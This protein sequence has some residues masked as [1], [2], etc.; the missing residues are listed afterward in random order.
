MPLTYELDTHTE[1][2]HERGFL[3]Q[4]NHL[5]AV[6]LPPTY[7][8]VQEVAHQ[9]PILLTERHLRTRVSSMKELSIEPSLDGKQLRKLKQIYAYLASAWVQAKGE[10]NISYIPRQIAVPL[11]QL[12][13]IL[14]VQPIVT[15]EDY[16]L[17]NWKKKDTEGPFIFDNMELIQHFEDQEGD[18]DGFILIHTDIEGRG[19]SRVIE[20]LEHAKLAVEFDQPHMV[21]DGLE[22]SADGLARMNRTMARMPETCR[23]ERYAEFV[24]PYIFGFNE[25]RYEG[26]SEKPLSFHG[27][28][29]AQSSIVPCIDEALGIQH[30]ETGLTKLLENMRLYMPPR[31][32]AV[33]A[34]MAEGQA[35]RAYAQHGPVY[36]RTAYNDCIHEL[37]NF[38]GTHLRYAFE[39]IEAYEDYLIKKGVLHPH[40]KGKGTGGSQYKHWLLQLK[41]ERREHL[42]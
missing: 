25:I 23:K 36:L 17:N 26:V 27:E 40:Q 1:P 33:V 24:R 3:P 9:L 35:I 29:G 2:T 32:R 30:K 8:E 37:L 39:F 19:G 21:A 31:H 10:K 11:A 20:G 34:E 15:Y 14:G 28:T 12:A 18:E 42:L 7:E 6:E 5:E 38:N 16:C 41:E 4:E 22:T 13:N